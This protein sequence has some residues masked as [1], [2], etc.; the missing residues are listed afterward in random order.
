MRHIFSIPTSQIKI[1]R[2]FSIAGV[3]IAL[4]KCRLQ[5]KNLHTRIDPWIGYMKPIDFA[6]ACE[7]ESN[8]TMEVEVEFQDEVHCEDFLYLNETL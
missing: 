6:L 4:C 1:E 8:L 5:T 7:V 3:L 2:I